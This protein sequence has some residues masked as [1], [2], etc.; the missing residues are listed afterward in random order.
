[1]GSD[2]VT[3]PTFASQT[4]KMGTLI[5]VIRQIRDHGRAHVPAGRARRRSY[6]R[7]R[8]PRKLG[9]GT[10]W[11]GEPAMPPSESRVRRPAGPT[12]DFILEYLASDYANSYAR[13]YFESTGTKTTNLA[14]TNSSKIRDFRFHLLDVDE[15]RRI[16]DFLDAETASDRSA[17]DRSTPS[18]R[19][20]LNERGT[21]RI[22]R[23]ICRSLS[24]QARGSPIVPMRMGIETAR[25]GRVTPTI[26]GNVQPSGDGQR[27]VDSAQRM[28]IGS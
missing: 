1:M 12:V 11:D 3:L 24:R 4:F 7:R 9:R 17:D 16:A 23:T 19:N 21:S 6:D 14:S 8:R 22:A 13:A 25:A 10:V 20:C 5:S 26:R 15:Q 18:T 28:F 27:H 2:S